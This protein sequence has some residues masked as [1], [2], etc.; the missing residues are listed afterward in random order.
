MGRDNG[1]RRDRRKERE[2]RE[3]A[4]RAGRILSITGTILIVLVIVLCCLLVLPG[5][6]SYQMF[7]VISGSMEPAVKVGSL[8]YVHEG[9]PER[10][11]EKDIIAFYGMPEGGIIT[12]RV[13]ENNVVSGTFITKGDANDGEDPTPIPYDNYIGKVTLTVPYMGKVLT[14]MTSF[15][16]KIAAACVVGLGAVLNFIGGR[17]RKN[18]DEI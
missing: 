8:I 18:K 6:F 2:G 15:H 4:G 12:H 10:I 3:S 9:E 13:V 16:G 5:A 7:N 11:A 1:G 14:V 17:T